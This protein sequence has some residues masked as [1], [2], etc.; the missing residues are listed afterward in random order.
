ML[1][2]SV[3]QRGGT[4]SKIR[5]TSV[6]FAPVMYGAQI[7]AIVPITVRIIGDELVRGSVESAPTFRIRARGPMDIADIVVLVVQ[8][9][10]L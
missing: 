1:R 4:S 5:M 6:E 3:E 7:R 8:R 9:C 10:S 2:S